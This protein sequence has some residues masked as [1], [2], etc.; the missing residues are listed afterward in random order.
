MFIKIRCVLEEDT[1]NPTADM[2]KVLY[3]KPQHIILLF[4]YFYLVF[5]HF[6]KISKMIFK[7]FP[8]LE[9]SYK[10]EYKT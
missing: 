5:C 6:F 1:F 10:I 3:F 9:Y 8:F 4:D 2:R 7:I